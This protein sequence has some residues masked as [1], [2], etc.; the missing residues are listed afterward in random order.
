M[1]F[2]ISYMAA[3]INLST[4]LNQHILTLRFVTC[5]I[6]ILGTLWM[7]IFGDTQQKKNPL[8]VGTVKIIYFLPK[9]LESYGN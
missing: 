5:I 9:L 8:N 6:M 2:L 7:S 4:S 1:D 3:K